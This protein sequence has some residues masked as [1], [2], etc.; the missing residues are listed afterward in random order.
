MFSLPLD[1]HV[2][3]FKLLRR[4][5]GGFPGANIILQQLKEGADRKRVGFLSSGPP[6]RGH[7]NI[8]DAKG[9]HIHYFDDL[10]VHF[11]IFFIKIGY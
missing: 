5:S 10:T 7:C 3:I 4:I 9:N 1:R 8:T 2:F 6:V 11:F